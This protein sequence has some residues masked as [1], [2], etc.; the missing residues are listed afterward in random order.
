MSQDKN[1]PKDTILDKCKNYLDIAA[2]VIVISCVIL[3]FITLFKSINGNSSLE[4]KT[5]STKPLIVKIEIP[6]NFKKKEDSLHIANY[7]KIV[8]SINENIKSL[9]Q[10]QSNIEVKEKEKEEETRFNITII[11]IIFTCVGFFGFKSIFDTR[12]AAIDKAVTEAKEKAEKIA[13]KEA[14]KVAEN[15]ATEVAENKA[16]EVAE[17]ETKNY[18]DN[19]L[20]EH[21]RIIEDATVNKLNEDIKSLNEDIDEIKYAYK[22]SENNRPESIKEIDSNFDK[23]VT[24]INA[25]KAEISAIKEDT[26]QNLIVER[27][28]NKQNGNA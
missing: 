21:L 1:P 12:Q 6:E 27:L 2:V 13:E 11:A 15:K 19:R 28:K 20:R 26:L 4:N 8:D 10:I 22:V 9:G 17:K 7:S 18:L 3:I 16:T 14:T 5:N 23:I 25:L 24:E